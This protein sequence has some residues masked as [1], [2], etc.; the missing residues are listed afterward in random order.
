MDLINSRAETGGLVGAPTPT[1]KFFFL[2]PPLI[3]YM[4]LAKII[5]EL[6]SWPP[7]ILFFGSAPE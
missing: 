4:V 7:L 3:I 6:K 1:R 5:K 2:A